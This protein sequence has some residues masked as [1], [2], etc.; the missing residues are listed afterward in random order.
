MASYHVDSNY[1]LFPTMRNQIHIESYHVDSNY[2]CSYYVD[3][4]YAW[5]SVLS[6]RFNLLYGILPCGC[7][8]QYEIKLRT[9]WHR[10]IWI[11]TTRGILQ[12]W[13]KLSRWSYD[14]DQAR[15][16]ILQFVQC[17]FLHGGISLRAASYNMDST[18]ERNPSACCEW[19]KNII[20][21]SWIDSHK[22]N[23]F[24]TLITNEV[25][26]N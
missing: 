10:T 4:N 18:F 25:S 5:Y 21:P 24:L 15:C 8:P 2:A 12:C 14:V 6:Y 3:S 9:V 11:H 7:I 23:Y 26:W 13:F 16:G 22:Q 17:G 1:A 20:L 19:K